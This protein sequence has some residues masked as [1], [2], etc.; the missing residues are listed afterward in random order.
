MRIIF[1][2]FSLFLLTCCNTNTES[3]YKIFEENSWN[4]DSIIT[5]NQTVVD[6]TT[7]HNLYLKIRHSTDFEYQNIFLFIDFQETR[8]TIEVILSEKNGKWLGKGVG[9]VKEVE[10]CFAKDIT[11]SSKKTSIVNIEQAMRY[12]DQPVITNLKGI[13]ALGLKIK[14]SE[15]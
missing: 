13:I 14:K 9:D 15:D 1:G 6:S 2:L 7:R 5:L 3:T 12:G 11:F 8:D 4:S 10:H